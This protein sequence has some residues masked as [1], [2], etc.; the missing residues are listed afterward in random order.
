[1]TVE[2]W[3]V[4]ILVSS[5][6]SSIIES[7]CDKTMGGMVQCALITAEECS[8]LPEIS[9]TTDPSNEGPGWTRITARPDEL[10]TV[11]VT[12]GTFGSYDIS[13]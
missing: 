1:M 2:A 9:Y 13:D 6:I 3:H 11:T 12:S 8:F 4:A 10:R 5:R 7:G